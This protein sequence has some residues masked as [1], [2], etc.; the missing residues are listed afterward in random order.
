[1]DDFKELLPWLDGKARGSHLEFTPP[2]SLAQNMRS[3]L[4]A[5]QVRRHMA[6]CVWAPPRCQ[7]VCS[8][9]IRESGSSIGIRKMPSCCQQVAVECFVPANMC[10]SLWV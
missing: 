1:M 6:G 7:A 8:S 4:D 5:Y 3:I 9:K 10:L 2:P